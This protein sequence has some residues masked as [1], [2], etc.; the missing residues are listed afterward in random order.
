[1]IN[2][3]DSKE[4]DFTNNGLVILNDCISCIVE[5]ELNGM[6]EAT[7]EYPIDDGGKWQYLLEGNITKIDGQLFRCYRKI[8]KLTSISVNLRAIF[9]DLLDNFLEDVRPT[10][11]NGAGALDWVLTNTQYTHPFTSLSDVQTVA[12][13]YFVRKNPVEAIMG[14]DGIINT[15]GGELVR[16]NFEISLLGARGLDRGVLVAYGKNVQGIEETLDLDGVCTRLMPVGKDGLLLAEKY[17]DSIYINNFSHPKIKIIELSDY[18]TEVTLRAAAINYMANNK[19]DIPQFNY[20]IDFLELSKT[21]EYKNYAVLERVYL[22]DTVTIKHSKLNINLKAKVIKT[23]KNIITNRIEKIELGSFKPN[24]ATSINN[25]IQEVKQDI[26]QVKSDYQKAIDN[27]TDLITGTNGGN[28]VIRQDDTTGKP[29]EIL[30][31]DTTDVMTAMKC[32]RFNLGGLGYS[33]TGINGPYETAI[34]MDGSI[35]G[36]FIT[37]LSISASQIKTNELIVGDNIAMGSNAVIAWNNL[38]AESQANLT[39]ADGAITYTWIKYASDSNGANMSDLPTLSPATSISLWY[40]VGSEANYDWLTI[41]L[42]GVQEA[43]VSGIGVWQNLIINGLT[44]GNHTLTFTYSTDSSSQLNGNFGAIDDVTLIQ[45][46][47]T[48]LEDFED[49]TFVFTLNGDWARSS[50]YK[51]SGLYSLVSYAIGASSSSAETLVFNVPSPSAQP[52]MGIAYNKLT[53]T[54]SL[55]A[56]DYAWSLIQGP[57]GDQANLPSY[58]TSTKITQTTIESPTIVGGLIQ[59]A[60]VQQLNGATLLADLYKDI[61]GGKLRINDINGDPNVTIGSKIIPGTVGGTLALYYGGTNQWRVGMAINDITHGGYMYLKDNLN[62][63]RAIM[64]ADNQT[65]GGPLIGCTGT[66]GAYKTWMTDLG[67]HGLGKISAASWSGTIPVNN[68]LLF[69]HNL[70][71]KPIVRFD[72]TVGNIVLTTMD[73][74]MDQIRVYSYGNPWTG[75]VYLW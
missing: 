10:S 40:L 22:G 54:E 50:T 15:W 69:T 8:K 35:V 63:A 12:T 55:I 32:W 71:Y 60:E 23:I 16:D 43:R 11:L 75:T 52:Y 65:T 49:N 17:I 72:G 53:P 59:G 51:H 33:S 61:N 21:E 5:E 27:A 57:Q 18:E 31:M 58:I 30:I 34:T 62:L 39:G 64:E 74:S 36:K 38:S 41:L 24:L 7:I 48:T 28:V 42:D 37:A 29:Y 46:P 13:R 1:M 25:A 6:L 70:G 47:V 19:I 4:T 67:F 20:K 56:S 45:G 3:Y 14:K 66:D 9:Y 73:M 2:L 44:A 68:F 26:V